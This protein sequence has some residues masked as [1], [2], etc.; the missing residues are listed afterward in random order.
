MTTA[1]TDKKEKPAA[2]EAQ[3]E[4]APDAPAAG[5]GLARRW[6]MTKAFAKELMHEHE[7]WVHALAVK[8]GASA[9]VIASVL[10]VSYV[11]A[12]PFMLAAAGI[13]ACGAVVG[14]GAYGIVAGG[15]R[16]WYRLRKIYANVTG[17]PLPPKPADKGPNWW[18]RQCEKP[19]VRKVLETPVVKGFLNSR[20]WKM[21]QKL[22]TGQQ[23]NVLG[24]IAVG[25]AAISLV[26]GA[27]ALATQ[28][29][30][31]PVVA[32]G[33][34]ITVAAVTA[35]SY[36]VSGISGL[37]FGITGIRHM[38][39]KKRAK[40]AALAAAEAQQ[41]AEEPP[42][43]TPQATPE[44]GAARAT[45]TATPPANDGFNAAAAKDAAPTPAADAPAGKNETPP[46][47]KNIAGPKS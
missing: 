34:L 35:T 2:A 28:I 5:G 6:R 44:T 21:T 13:A 36:L 43:A 9:I 15:A 25:G 32:L 3:A 18:Q 11:V 30:V 22:T 17:K 27:A 45:I 23:D 14:L 46:A 39:E 37:Y 12:A 20:A 4:S 8:G 7:F 16:S 42:A 1:D 41:A 19:A 38:R 24:G 29:L 40:A 47:R 33:G 10:A 31:L 26:L